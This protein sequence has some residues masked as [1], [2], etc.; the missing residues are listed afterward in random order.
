MQGTPNFY[1]VIQAYKLW[2]IK[3]YPDLQRKTE[4]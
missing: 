2:N 1:L 4:I 3:K